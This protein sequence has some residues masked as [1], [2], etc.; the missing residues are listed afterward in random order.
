MAFSMALKGVQVLDF[1]LGAKRIAAFRTDRNV[2]VAAKT[3]FL[4]VAVT[5]A[6]ILENGSERAQVSAG[7]FR[8]AQ[9]RLADDFQ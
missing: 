4:H 3:A 1:D 2:G 5:D 7:F 9:V 8:R 6:E